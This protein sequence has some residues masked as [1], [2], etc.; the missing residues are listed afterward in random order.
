MSKETGSINEKKKAID[1]F[2]LCSPLFLA[3]GDT[4]RQQLLLDIADCSE[5]GCNV[6][7]LTGKTRLSRS[8]ISYHLKILKDS[9]LITARKKGTQVFYFLHLDENFVIIRELVDTLQRLIAVKT[10]QLDGS[11][12]PGLKNQGEQQIP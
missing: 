7:E 5:K 6:A 11:G 10:R 1:L 3:M 4:V 2:H 9:G 8:A 12:K